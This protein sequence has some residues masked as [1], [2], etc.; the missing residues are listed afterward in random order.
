MLSEL[1]TVSAKGLTDTML[2]NWFAALLGGLMTVLGGA[3][4]LAQQSSVRV[5]AVVNDDIITDVDLAYR[6]NLAIMVAEVEN[7]RERRLSLAPQVLDK[8][9]S[10][11]IRLQESDRLGIDIKD[12]FVFD[13]FDSIA[14]QNKMDREGFEA[15]I[16][17]S[18]VPA[19][20]MR[21]QIRAQI[22]LNAITQ[23]QIISDVEIS[24]KELMAEVNRINA[25]R[26]RS[27]RQLVEIFLPFNRQ[28]SASAVRQQALQIIEQLQQG[29]DFGKLAQQFSYAPT[30]GVGGARG[31][32]PEGSLDPQLEA[33]L[34]NL[35]PGSITQ[36]PIQTDEGL[37]IMG[38]LARRPIGAA[39]SRT[40]AALRQLYLN[41]PE[42]LST[43][44]AQ[45]RLALLTSVSEQVRGCRQFDAAM[46]QYGEEGSGNLG[47]ID[48]STLPPII[49]V[50]LSELDVGEVS[51][52]LPTD[53][54]GSVFMVCGKRVEVDP[55]TA[56]N[57]RERLKNERVQTL[58]RRYDADLRRDAYIDYRF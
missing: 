39:S 19:D 25:L 23:R 27:E 48:L 12:T 52:P 46:A 51:P 49:S 9:V 17:Q 20:V 15:L 4:A 3:N 2:K 33:G 31:W 21:E 14:A 26:G 40:I 28:S 47:E 41:L 29:S 37:Y 30:A 11:K 36:Q 43:P 32:V 50:T 58:A 45:Q 1:E 13:A 34:A 54:G 6:I 55:L 5:L 16:R 57:V 7:T 44:I 56:E 53:G 22:A 24:D 10:D 38:I 18:G 42:D 35:R 8:L